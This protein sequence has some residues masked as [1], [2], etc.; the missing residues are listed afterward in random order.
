MTIGDDVVAEFANGELRSDLLAGIVDGV[1]LVLGRR[2][3]SGDRAGVARM[4]ETSVLVQPDGTRL[5]VDGTFVI[6]YGFRSP[7]V[8]GLAVTNR[9]D[10]TA[11]LDPTTGQPPLRPARAGRPD[12]SGRGTTRRPAAVRL[13]GP[14]RRDGSTVGELRKEFVHRLAIGDGLVG[15]AGVDGNLG[16]VRTAD[17][18]EVWRRDAAIIAPTALAFTGDHLLVGTRDGRVIEHD[19]AGSVARIIDVGNGPVTS[20]AAA[21]GT[22]VVGVDDVIRGYRTDGDGLTS[23]DQVTV[24]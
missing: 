9:E 18:Q 14:R 12:P 5:E 13:V 23:R 8:V 3:P 24:P 4:T 6:S 20:I 7:E 10:G 19:S 22:L 16:V 15:V 1:V 21:A 2:V 11:L 17:G